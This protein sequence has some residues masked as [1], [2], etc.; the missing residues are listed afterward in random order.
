[1][2]S[3]SSSTPVVPPSPG[4][5]PGITVSDA[6]GLPD[7]WTLAESLKGERAAGTTKIEVEPEKA[8][9]TPDPDA[10]EKQKEEEKAAAEQKTIDDD[11]AAAEAAAAAKTPAAKPGEKPAATATPKPGEKPAAGAAAKPA[12]KP[13][14]AATATP[15]PAAAPAKIKIGDKEYT[16]EELKKR[17]ETPAAPAPAAPAKPTTEPKKEP[18]A[19]EKAA[20]TAKTEKIESE[21][22]AGAAQALKPSAVDEATMEK[23]LTGGKDAVE[24]FDRIRREDMA[25]TVLAV[26]KDLGELYKPMFDAVHQMQQSQMTQEDQRMWGAFTTAHP[27][28]A[29]HETLVK[30]H[31]AALVE[32]DP[33]S[34]SKMNE[35]E[36]NSKVAEMTLGYIRQFNP[37]FGK[38]APANG[39]PAAA[40]GAAP[41]PAALSAA[42]KTLA[43]AKPAARV[44]PKPPA[45]SLPAGAP[46]GGGGRGGNADF[47]KSAVAS[48]M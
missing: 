3:E 2:G 43:A 10:M 11:K 16:E 26:R 1:M 14:P 12:A 17:L 31:A 19:E 46:A 36:F 33:E 18:T 23:I 40:P 24:A 4:K 20:E 48:L 35:T 34:V 8:E 25:R 45:G 9:G 5:L 27:A 37:E 15:A 21:W 39:A 41:A 29:Q 13:A 30:Q 47:Q 42:A 7:N 44:T 32:A 6:F 22:I 28:L 38:D